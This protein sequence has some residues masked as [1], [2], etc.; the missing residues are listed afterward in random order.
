M[1]HFYMYTWVPVQER[2]AFFT[3]VGKNAS[4]GVPGVACNLFKVQTSNFK[5]KRAMNFSVKRYFNCLE[6][7][8]GGHLFL[9]MN[10]SIL[11]FHF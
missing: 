3:V 11:G 8:L 10:C 5:P 2:V 1:S 7:C 6:F 4:S 9:F